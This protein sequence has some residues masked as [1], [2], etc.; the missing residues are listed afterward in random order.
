VKVTLIIPLDWVNYEEIQ[1]EVNMCIPAYIL[2]RG[3]VVFDMS[4]EAL[5]FDE[6]GLALQGER[7]IDRV[8]Q[9][10]LTP[11]QGSLEDFS[12]IDESSISSPSR[13]SRLAGV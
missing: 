13:R 10:Q 1:R 8:P 11:F 9:V 12:R 6:S 5:I 7:V 4:G 3:T 2:T